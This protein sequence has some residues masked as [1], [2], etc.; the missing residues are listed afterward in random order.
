M[1]CECVKTGKGPADI[2]TT[3]SG[4]LSG[5]VIIV[6][7]RDNQQKLDLFCGSLLKVRRLDADRVYYWSFP[8]VIIVST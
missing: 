5:A 7:S 6:S 3:G 1:T 2:E 4:R 8:F